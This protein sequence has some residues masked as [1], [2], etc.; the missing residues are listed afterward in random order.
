M[1]R[2]DYEVEASAVFK[3]EATDL[4]EVKDL[5]ETL[6]KF[7]YSKVYSHSFWTLDLKYHISHL[8]HK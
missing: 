2:D 8:I 4:T 3:R 5:E 1:E 6:A 7:G